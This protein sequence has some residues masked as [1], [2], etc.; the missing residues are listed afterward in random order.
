MFLFYSCGDGVEVKD[1]DGS[2]GAC[3]EVERAGR[4]MN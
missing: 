2:F 1:N 4:K 3:V